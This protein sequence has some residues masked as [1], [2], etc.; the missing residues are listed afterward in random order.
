MFAVPA[1]ALALFLRRRP[2]AIAGAWLAAFVVLAVMY[3][4]LRGGTPIDV[5]TALELAC[6]LAGFGFCFMWAQSPR[7]VK[8]GALSLPTVACVVLMVANV[9]STLTPRIFEIDLLTVWPAL[10][11]LQGAAFGLVLVAQLRL[12]LGKGRSNQQ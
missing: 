8:D 10:V 1:L 6:A 3:P 12:L 7:L 9:I 4:G 11:G 5:Y 2:W